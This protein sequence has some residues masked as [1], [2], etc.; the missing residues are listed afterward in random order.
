[1]N[2]PL[3]IACRLRTLHLFLIFACTAQLA[4]GYHSD[5]Q[6]LPSGQ[7][8]H[9]EFELNVGQS[10]PEVRYLFRGDGYTMFLTGNAALFKIS[11][12]LA[13]PD[14]RQIRPDAVRCNADSPTVPAYRVGS[15]GSCAKQVN[16]L[17]LALAD[18]NHRAQPVG[19]RKLGSYSN[20]IIGRDPA[21]WWARVPQFEQVWYEGVYRGIDL[22]YHSRNGNLEYDLRV[23]PHANPGAIHFSVE[24]IPASSQ[25]AINAN[26]DLVLGSSGVV[27]RRPAL[28]QGNDCFLSDDGGDQPS[29]TKTNCRSLPGGGFVLKR[30]RS[31]VSIGFKLPPY[32]HN[33]TLIIDPAISFGTYLGGEIGSSANAVKTDFA[34]NIYVL[35]STNSPDFPTTPGAFQRTLTGN[36]GVDYIAKFSPDGSKLIYSTFLAGSGGENP[37]AI[38][39]D[40]AGSP[41][42]IGTTYSKDYPLANAFQ[43]AATTPCVSLSKLTPDGSGLVYSTYFGYGSQAGGLAVD[44]AGE[45]VVGGSVGLGT[46]PIVN[47][48]QPTHG[49]D[50]G[51]L[52]GFVSKFDASGT[53]LIF[54]TYWG[55]NG[56]DMVNGVA[57]DSGGNAY[58][59][60]TTTSTDLI[61]TPGVFEGTCQVN[62]SGGCQSSFVSAF[63]PSGSALIYSSYLDG[64]VAMSIAVDSADEA[65]VTGDV[66]YYAT[67][68]VTTPGSFRPTN[69]GGPGTLDAFI[70][71]FNNSG[72]SL[73][74][75][76][77][78][79]GSDED[80]GIAIAT[81]GSGDAYVTGNTFSPDFPL[82]NPVLPFNSPGLTE[83]FISEIDST[84]SQ[85]L[86]ST[87]YGGD[88]GQ[89]GNTTAFAI[90]VDPS[91]N[92]VAV[93]DTTS[94]DLPVVN[95]FQAQLTG[96]GSSYIA[97]ITTAPDFALS[98]SPGAISVT[99]GQ[100]AD[101][102]LSVTALNGF[103][104]KV[105]LSCS[106][107][108]TGSNCS[109][110]PGSITPNG[111]ASMNASVTVSTSAA[112][113]RSTVQYSRPFLRA[114]SAM[115]GIAAL[116]TMLLVTVP[117]GAAGRKRGSRR[118][119][120]WITFLI[121]VSALNLTACGGGSG[122]G[123]SG[124]GGPTPSGTYDLI[125]TGTS[126]SGQ[127]QIS[128]SFHFSLT[129][130]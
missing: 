12:P 82:Q 90:D 88:A 73:V 114:R 110:S 51:I 106:G 83:T 124:G 117:V 62:V 66:P 1:M 69:T 57:V 103:S 102:S 10:S 92:I 70:T 120:F 108:P 28:Y 118:C 80:I 58:A 38:A 109:V 50:G 41:Y 8:H 16:V 4:Y 20:Y 122:S 34:G 6:L 19:Q 22:V 119:H 76:T 130:N 11:F 9:Q 86:F 44:S 113:G 89:Y 33:Q 26:G 79:G 127:G 13:T 61:T 32:D 27:F 3:Q 55:G 75:S 39:V 23:A 46:F 126:G 17:R 68:F 29:T 99:A 78:L 72:S 112:M 60:G 47:A 31:L 129:V 71:K 52:D 95:A 121:I 85:L 91:K 24:G 54:S 94:P 14:P 65:M 93:G 128:H 105:T 49:S 36:F 104:Q 115:W 123:G 125:V 35:G 21:K 74:Y 116:S 100:V 81:D 48:V 45:A 40:S 53:S 18:S 30:H 42:V 87:Y 84:G 96:F 64:A 15:G 43:S 63:K 98:G 56:G 67:N 5:P 2:F 111:S 7:A 77:L 37:Y 107:A 97:K 101:F 59:T 25:V